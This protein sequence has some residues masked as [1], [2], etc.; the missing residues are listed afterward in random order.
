[1]S[2]RKRPGGVIDR[3]K[4]RTAL[5]NLR[6]ESLFHM[7]DAAIDLLP[8]GKMANLVGGYLDVKELR[9]DA[10]GTRNLLADVRAFEAGSRAGK[11]YEG[12]KVNSKNFMEKS[13]GTRAFIDDCCG[14][15]DRCVTQS[16]EGDAAEVL[17]GL[18][19]ILGLLRDLDEGNDD[20][21]FFADEAG[22]WQ[23]GVEWAKVLPAL[24]LCLSRTT[25]PDEYA[26][27][28]VE[29]VDQ[30]AGLDQAKHLSTARRLG[31]AAQRR[32][33]DAAMS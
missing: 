12:F 7:L 22:L 16:R 33:C 15:L 19:L 9:P 30:F 32:A 24:F 18:D 13:R 31:T 8:P 27:R 21:V 29:A 11:Y 3:D 28:V 26:R 2:D 1:M 10:A 5:R 23:V 4:L 25:E 14:L 6:H 17:E 20:I